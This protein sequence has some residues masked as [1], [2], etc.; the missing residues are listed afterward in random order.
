MN[1]YLNLWN[2]DLPSDYFKFFLLWDALGIGCE[3]YYY[4]LKDLMLWN[5]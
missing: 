2:E 1:K 4:I 5:S 3:I